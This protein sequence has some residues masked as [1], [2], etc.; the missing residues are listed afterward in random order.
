MYTNTN[1]GALDE[2]SR[3][4]A[5][6]INR[7]YLADEAQCLGALLDTARVDEAMRGRISRRARAL[8]EGVRGAQTDRSG[9][10]AFLSRYDL[11]SKEGV[12]LMCL[13]EALLRIPDDATADRLIAD[14]ISAGDWASHLGDSDSLFVNAS[15]W[16]LMLTGRLMR[17]TD[18][19][20]GDHRGIVGRLASRLGEPVLRAAFRQ[21]MRI[22]GRQFV[23]GRTIEEALERADEE[24]REYR[25]SFDMLGEAALTK[26]DAQRY[27]DAYMKAIAAVSD[28]ASG[29]PSELAPSIS[30]KLSALFP[31]YEFL[32]RRR[33][34]LELAPVLI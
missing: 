31:R 9:L 27:F 1:S 33:V 16:G 28:R 32:Q 4:V 34:H 10:D 19:E 13:A 23:M 6:A 21:A 3:S 5:N 15:T 30:V 11:S 29:K 17:P 26:L 7:N 18:D 12:I 20:L 25:H 2:P 24:Q 8:V 14:K 22:M